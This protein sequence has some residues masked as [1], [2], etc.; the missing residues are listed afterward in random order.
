MEAIVPLT[1]SWVSSWQR[2][3]HQSGWEMWDLAG[4]DPSPRLPNPEI[5]W[6]DS[7][8]THM[9]WKRQETDGWKFLEGERATVCPA[10]NGEKVLR[11]SAHYPHPSQTSNWTAVAQPYTRHGR[12]IRHKRNETC[13]ALPLTFH[14]QIVR[15]CFH[16]LKFRLKFSVFISQSVSL[17]CH[18]L[19]LFSQAGE[20]WL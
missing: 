13:I 3:G 12:Y 1:L 14:F 17:L 15:P 18:A 5:Q 10:S 19:S 8:A 11:A 2:R 9:R 6:R 20:L 7:T 16:A 4:I